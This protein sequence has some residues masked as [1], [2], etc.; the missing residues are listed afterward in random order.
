MPKAA[1]FYRVGE[2]LKVEEI[3]IPELKSNEVLLRIRAASMC[4]S[5]LHVKTGLIAVQGPVTLGHEI[6]GDVEEVGPAVRNLRRGDRAVVHFLGPCGVCDHCRRGKSNVCR[7]INSKP[8]YGFSADGGYAEYIKVES[9]RIVL[10]APEVQYE[11]G[12]T[13]GCAG[14]TALHAVSSI[15]KIR[16]GNKIAVYGTG[17][18]GMYVL[19]L[20]KLS[21]A[22]F[23]IAIGRTD[24]K[25]QM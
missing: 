5:D 9:D 18:V 16:L 7:N 10:L 23:T 24:E 21:G 17:G 1:R 3:A 4:H 22:A 14:I 6:A 15:A 2:P 8:M 11:F 19:Q 25:L 12:A 20:A 13:L